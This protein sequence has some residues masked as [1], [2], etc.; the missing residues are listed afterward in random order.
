MP[1]IPSASGVWRALKCAASCVLPDVGLIVGDAARFGT[2]VHLFLEKV[3][4]VGVD[5]AL[6]MVP[7]EYRG[8][9]SN[10]PLERLPVEPGKFRQEV[11]F[12]L[13]LDT[14]ACAKLG[15]SIGRNY[16]KVYQRQLNGTADVLS[17]VGPRQGY[18][19][20][21]KSGSEFNCPHPSE[22]PQMLSLATMA[23]AFYGWESVIA[24][25]HF[26]RDG[27]V[28]TKRAE[29]DVLTLDAWLSTLRRLETSI[30]TMDVTNPSMA[31]GDWCTWCSS[32]KVCPAKTKL[33]SAIV[34]GDDSQLTL[35]LDEQTLPTIWERVEQAQAI[36]DAIRT[37]CQGFAQATPVPLPDGRVFGPRETSQE[38]VK[39]GAKVWEYLMGKYGTEV[40]EAGTTRHT[41]KDLLHEAL[42]IPCAEAK[43]K[44]EKV[45]LAQMERGVLSEL[46]QIGAIADVVTVKV[47][48]HFPKA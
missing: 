28:F 22:N 37:A 23:A 17:Q 44:G 25:I 26:V 43:A 48:P 9:C 16:P 4:Q 18:V 32:F 14:G 19:A 47:E 3:P 36:L 24:E 2:A 35:R 42:R 15:E 27:A 1:R 10:I 39:D 11:A 33:A 38:R 46:R 29:Y 31:E 13:D 8:F 5:A 7:A 20:D 41:S 21:Y 12:A 6:D 30:R 40:A 34:L 45:S